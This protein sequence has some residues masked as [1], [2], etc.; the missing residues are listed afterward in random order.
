MSDVYVALRP[1]ARAEHEAIDHYVLECAQ[2]Q[3]VR[4]V[5]HRTQATAINAAKRHGHEPLVATVRV[6]DRGKP[7]HARAAADSPAAPSGERPRKSVQLRGRRLP[8]RI[9]TYSQAGAQSGAGEPMLAGNFYGSVYG[10]AIGASLLNLPS[11][12][13]HAVTFIDGHPVTDASSE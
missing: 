8:E 11:H 12:P 6:T 4:D 7:D 1:K 9:A 10:G 3:S 13:H 2:G 5:E